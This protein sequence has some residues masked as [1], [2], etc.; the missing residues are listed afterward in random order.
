E[1]INEGMEINPEKIIEILATISCRKAIKSGDNLTKEEALKLIQ[2]LFSIELRY[3]C[4]HGRPTTIYIDRKTFEKL[5]F[6][7]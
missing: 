7:T 6:R 4:P 5:F 3:S 1:R 2:T